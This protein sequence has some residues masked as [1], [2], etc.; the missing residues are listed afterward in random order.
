MSHAVPGTATRSSGPAWPQT[1][2]ISPTG[3]QPAAAVLAIGSDSAT[4]ADTATIIRALMNDLP[5]TDL[6]A[7]SFQF[8][9]SRLVAPRPL[10]SDHRR[11]SHEARSHERRTLH[12][13]TSKLEAGSWK[14]LR[15]VV[16][17]RCFLQFRGPH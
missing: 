15:S 9:A 3:S 10:N 1:N 14:L 4:T 5:I 2:R 12:Q 8:R 11:T 6:E 17:L 7:S 16:V 13:A